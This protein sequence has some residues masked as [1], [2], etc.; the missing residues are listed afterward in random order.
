MTTI[1]TFPKARFDAMLE[2]ARGFDPS[3]VA[4]V[5]KTDFQR[6]F[7][8][9]VQ[10]KM[11]AAES[12][13]IAR[14]LEFMRQGVLEVQYPELKGSRLVPVDTAIDPGAA[15]YTYQVS[16]HVGKALVTSD[17]ATEPPRAD[18]KGSESNQV[19]RSIIIAYGYSIQ[20]A[21]AAM[22]AKTPL[23]PRKAM[24]ARDIMER[25]IDDI[26]FL[27]DLV[28]GLKGL[29]NQSST[30]T[31]TI[32]AGAGGTKAWDSGKTPD[33]II[34]DMNAA[35]NKVVSDSKEVF[36]PDTM[37]LPL[38]T[39]TYISTRRMGDGD[40]STIL[41]HFLK[42][43]PYVKT[44]EATHK[45]ESNSGWTGKRGMCYRKDPNFIAGLLPQPFEQLPP[46]ATAYELITPCH[47]RCGGVV[48]YQP[49]AICYFDEI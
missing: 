32:P 35:V 36:Q 25:T 11:D 48:V 23:I 12:A 39:Y 13:Y 7:D 8:A 26:W 38:S 42:N 37:L 20:E 46:Q 2:A 28:M 33:E 9:A 6:R 29:L 15:S 22:F 24:A 3:K 5:E 27:G 19:I 30:T 43:S 34:A 14:Q 41:Q 1:A 44:V 18:V 17:L 47:A 16:D 40:S 49:K 4:T 10:G 31:Y 21:R 45:L